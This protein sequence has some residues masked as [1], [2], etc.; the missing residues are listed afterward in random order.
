[1]RHQSTPMQYKINKLTVVEN[2]FLQNL[3]K[4]A[5]LSLVSVLRFLEGVQEPKCIL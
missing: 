5:A 2:L 4:V 1:M 3:K